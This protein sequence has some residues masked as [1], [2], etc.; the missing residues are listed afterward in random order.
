MI[1]EGLVLEDCVKFNE[2]SCWGFL[3]D[4]DSNLLFLLLTSPVR[5]NVSYC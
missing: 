5:V 2:P 4:A 3:N 1:S